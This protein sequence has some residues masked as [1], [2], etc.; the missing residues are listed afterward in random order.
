MLMPKAVLRHLT[1]L[2]VALLMLLILVLALKLSVVPYP[3]PSLPPDQCVLD[4]SK[5]IQPSERCGFIFD[6]VYYVS[7]ARILLKGMPAKTAHPNLEHPPLAKLLI[8]LGIEVFGDNPWGWRVFSAIASACSVYLVGLLA[9]ELTKDRMGSLIAA[10]LFAFD[11]TS[12][13]LGCMAILDPIALTFSLLGVLLYVRRRL[14]LAGAAFGLALL[15]KL[16]AAFILAAVLFVD[17][18]MSSFHAGN[19][20]E[21][22]RRWIGVVEKM[23]FTAFFIFIVGLGLYD[24]YYG[25]FATPFEHLDYMLRYHGSLLTYKSGEEI[26]FPLS[27]T[28]P[29]YQFPRRVYAMVYVTV[30]GKQY[31]IIAYYGMQ[32]P[33]W[34]MT[35]VVVGFSA[36]SLASELRRGGLSAS[37][38]LILSWFAFSYLIYFPIAHLL[39]RYVYPFYFYMTVPAIAIGLSRTLRG[40]PFTDLIL[41]LLLGIQLAWFILFFPVKPLWLAMKLVDLGL[42]H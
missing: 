5:G 11:I 37:D 7:V 15:S 1:R 13:N 27:W 33:L 3:W 10:S 17:L 29:V 6:E 30:N 21:A 20:G 36:Y 35:W 18:L 32:T 31:P 26:S 41:Y 39:R 28:N 2:R 38:L 16:P 22:L 9:Y 40:E 24:Y 4:L 19:L 14:F 25:V 12:F 34:W 42:P 23:G 8:M